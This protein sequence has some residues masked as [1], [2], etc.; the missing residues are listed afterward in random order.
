VSTQ[1]DRIARDKKFRELASTLK[2]YDL[3]TEYE[4]FFAR[5]WIWCVYA[6]EN[7]ADLENLGLDGF[8]DYLLEL[9]FNLTSAR[10]AC[11]LVETY[12]LEVTLNA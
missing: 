9:G 7:G 4:P 5:F 6:S 1:K 3:P 8:I 10:V 2:I 12:I 11:R